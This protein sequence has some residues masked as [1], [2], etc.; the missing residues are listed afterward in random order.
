MGTAVLHALIVGGE[1]IPYELERKAVKRLNLRVRRDGT[2]HV[3]V[4]IRMTSAAVERFLSERAE[5]IRDARGR[6]LARCGQALSLFEGEQIPLE[7]V[8]HKVRLLEGKKPCATRV[9]GEL[10]LT[11]P[12]PNDREARLRLFRRFVREE[13]RRVL[14]ARAQ[15]IYP[16]FAPRPAAF[17]A[18][19]V[20]WMR[21]RWGSCTASKNHITLNERLLFVEPYLAAYVIYHEFCH[22]RHP[23]HS[24]AF[25]A[26]LASFCPHYADARRALR[27]APVPELEEI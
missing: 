25:Y 13:A 18:L 5:W 8:L 24:P 19:T 3:S 9:A 17:P 27:A 20:R 15:A 10:I 21:S 16:L 4:P 22:F 7:G 2:V 6:M 14:T 1:T 11:L 23:N 26:H 12:D